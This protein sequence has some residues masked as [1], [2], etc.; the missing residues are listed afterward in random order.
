MPGAAAAGARTAAPLPRRRWWHYHRLT[1]LLPWMLALGIGFPLLW[2]HM[3]EVFQGPLR[4][5]RGDALDDAA[6]ALARA[7]DGLRRDARFLAELTAADLVDVARRPGA[8]S[9]R[10]LLVFARSAPAYERI[11]GIGADGAESMRVEHGAD[12][13]PRL[14]PV[15]ALRGAVTDTQ[16]E[17]A[18]HLS[19]GDV[20]FSGFDLP[21]ADGAALLPPQPLLRA[22]TPIYEKNTLRG[23]LVLELRAN[24]LLQSLPGST[25][26]PGSPT[27]RPCRGGPCSSTPTG[28]C[29][30]R[31][32]TGPIAGRTCCAPRACR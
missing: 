17:H 21:Q 6:D 2:N 19:A 15:Q 31:A 28:S 16:Y 11:Y 18:R 30:Q 14:A 20:Q 25:G 27:P 9:Q 7:A 8:D 23:V 3:D 13:N 26:T 5:A 4:R 10:L 24:A 22:A 12:A 1:L 29:R 32:A